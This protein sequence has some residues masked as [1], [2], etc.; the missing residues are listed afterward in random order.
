MLST[1]TCTAILQGNGAFSV[2]FDF[3]SAS[4]N[5]GFPKV[6]SGTDSTYYCL[7]VGTLRQLYRL[8]SSKNIHQ[9]LIGLIYF[10]YYYHYY[11][12]F[13][14]LGSKGSRG[15]KIKFKNTY[16]SWKS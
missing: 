4:Q 7:T 2:A 8:G 9:L 10:C 5:F 15:L 6:S 1:A 11:Y 12:Y 14:A 16:K 3:L 13:F